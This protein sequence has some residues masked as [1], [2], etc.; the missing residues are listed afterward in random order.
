MLDKTV[1]VWWWLV[2]YIRLTDVI[3]IGDN[4]ESDPPLSPLPSV[5]TCPLTWR[6][7]VR[8]HSPPVGTASDI[9]VTWYPALTPHS[10]QPCWRSNI[11]AFLGSALR[12][13]NVY[14]CLGGSLLWLILKIFWYL[15]TSGQEFNPL[16]WC[17]SPWQ[18]LTNLPVTGEMEFL[19]SEL[20]FIFDISYLTLPTY[21]ILM[22]FIIYLVKCE[23]G[24]DISDTSQTLIKQHN[25]HSAF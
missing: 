7:P 24:R 20:R 22:G 3:L 21:F 15:F 17:H 4:A 6:P 9:V 14:S 23:I 18:K 25:N 12:L 13:H 16:R 19:W 1:M 10:H 2:V 11:I 5:R 8:H